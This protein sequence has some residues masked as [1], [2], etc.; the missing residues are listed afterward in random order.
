MLGAGDAFMAGFLRGW[1]RAAPLETSLD[2]ANACG[3]LVVS[4]HGCAPAMPTWPELA[5]FL[6]GGPWP[7]RLRDSPELEHLHW[8]TTRRPDWPRGDRRSRST[9][10]CRTASSSGWR[11]PWP[12][13]GVLARDP[14]ALPTLFAAADHP[15]WL[16]R[17]ARR[18]CRAGRMALNHV[19]VA[20]ADALGDAALRR[21]ARDCRRTRHE[22]MLEADGAAAMQRVYGLGV[23]PGLVGDRRRRGLRRGRTGAWTPAI[24]SAAAFSSPET[25]AAPLARDRADVGGQGLHRQ[26]GRLRGAGGR[27]AR[28]EGRRRLAAGGGIA[29]GDDPPHR[30]AGAGPSPPGAVRRD[31]RGGRPLLRRRLGDLRPRQRG[32]SRRGLGGGR[33]WRCRPTA[34]TTS[35]RWRTRRSPSPRPTAGAARSPAPHR[36]GRGR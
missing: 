35:R 29:M 33:R 13:L 20:G 27:L 9:R 10:R 17:A 24:R 3:A 18:R 30:R 2:Y 31:R 5:A 21:L 26:A 34:P 7:H 22:L 12:G 11:A 6:E 1:L 25:R 16:A 32:G 23:S 8:A 15:C 28:G 36:S 19:V 4:R 14:A